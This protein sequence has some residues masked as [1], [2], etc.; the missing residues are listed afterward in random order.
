MENQAMQ[1]LE[2]W[3]VYRKVLGRIFDFEMR[4]IDKMGDTLFWSSKKIRHAKIRYDM[5]DEVFQ[6]ILKLYKED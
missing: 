4:E 3:R 1:M 6:E 2:R 5:L